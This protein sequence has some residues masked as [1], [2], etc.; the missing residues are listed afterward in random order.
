MCILL[1]TSE[2]KLLYIH[3][4]FIWY[5]REIHG[6][7][8]CH[9]SIG[10]LFLV[11]FSISG[12]ELSVTYMYYKYFLSL[13]VLPVH[14]FNGVSGNQISYFY[15]RSICKVFFYYYW[16]HF[17]VEEIFFPLKSHNNLWIFEVFLQLCTVWGRNQDIFFPHTQIQLS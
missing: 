6:Q 4:L 9:F 3:V 17:L 8:F 16:S 1:I 13:H 12:C 14:T 15:Y 2:I 5:T 10:F 7:V 11:C